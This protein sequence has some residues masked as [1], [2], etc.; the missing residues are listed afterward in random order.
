MQ[1]TP[2]RYVLRRETEC[3]RKYFTRSTP[4]SSSFGPVR[5]LRKARKPAREFDNE[6]SARGRIVRP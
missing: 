6:S 4:P 1:L 3:F 2:E 5:A